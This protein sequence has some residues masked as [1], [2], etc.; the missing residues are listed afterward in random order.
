M[1]K[2]KKISVI[3]PTYNEGLGILLFLEKLKEELKNLLDKYQPEIIVIDDDSPD[4]TARIIE[5]RYTQNE[6]IK[7]YVRKKT[8]GLGKRLVFMR[9]PTTDTHA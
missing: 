4:G 5:S 3:I 6:D 8:R 1:I 9:Q 7:V 2:K